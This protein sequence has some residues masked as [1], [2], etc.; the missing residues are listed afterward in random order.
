MTPEKRSITCMPMSDPRLVLLAINKTS[1]VLFIASSIDVADCCSATTSLY[2][3][4]E[5]SY[6]VL[7][8]VLIVASPATYNPSGGIEPHA[9]LIRLDA[10]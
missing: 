1:L 6:S 7:L 5:T 4:M 10:R 3:I 8:G 9:C 2:A